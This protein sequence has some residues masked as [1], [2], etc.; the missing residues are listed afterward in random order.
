MKQNS[1]LDIKTKLINLTNNM[2]QDVTY[3]F[4]IKNKLH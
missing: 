2:I 1:L 3:T 4:H